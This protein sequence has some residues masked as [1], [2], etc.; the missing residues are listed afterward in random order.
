MEIYSTRA[1]GERV[2]LAL[3]VQSG[4]GPSW[5]PVGATSVLPHDEFLAA[6]YLVARAVIDDLERLGAPP[7]AEALFM[8][9]VD[10]ARESDPLL[11]DGPARLSP[12]GLP[13][14]LFQDDE[15]GA[16]PLPTD[17]HPPPGTVIRSETAEPPLRGELY[18]GP[19]PTMHLSERDGD[20]FQTVAL[21]P[22]SFVVGIPPET[23]E[24]LLDLTFEARG[25]HERRVHE[26]AALSAAI[27]EV[28]RSAA[29]ANTTDDV[30]VQLRTYQGEGTEVLDLSTS[31]PVAGPDPIVCLRLTPRARA[32]FL[33]GRL[34][35]LV[36]KGG[37]KT[38]TDPT[39]E[40]RLAKHLAV[41]PDPA[42]EVFD[43][44]PREAA[45]V[46]VHGTMSCAVP[47]AGL[48]SRHLHHA[49]VHR[50]EHDTW[51]PLSV[52]AELLVDRL[53]A[54]GTERLL[55]VGHSRGGL[56][57][58]HAAAA[59]EHAHG[60]R[61]EVVTWGAPFRGTPLVGAAEVARSGASGLVSLLLDPTGLARPLLDQ[62][63]RWIARGLTREL[64]AGITDMKPAA[65]ALAAL[66][67]T[68]PVPTTAVGGR[69]QALHDTWGL[70]TGF[71]EGVENDHVV[72]TSSA[73]AA[74]GV[75]TRRLVVDHSHHDYAASDVAVTAVANAWARLR[76]GS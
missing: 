17:L 50:F 8:H 9:L 14:D 10:D 68:G 66:R 76:D 36:S 46:A 16:E 24:I 58:R 19:W 15:H 3:H 70:A 26:P 5:E 21:S 61:V 51:L 40:H 29:C 75:D 62:A 34:G 41:H 38:P 28:R 69:A 53:V 71:F 44:M 13:R 6:P 67:L 35:R 54:A 2:G 37:L 55:L 30:L 20:W 12:F 64:P 42:P 23:R 65:G 39:F 11:G 48:L 32:G 25:A 59:L 18:R 57:A 27:D 49:P 47:L 22:D 43:P 33:V 45:V 31:V 1:D 60:R 72:E 73:L 74:P 7:F 4:P 52:N 56:V 63:T